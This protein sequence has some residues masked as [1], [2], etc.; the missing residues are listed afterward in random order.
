MGQGSTLKSSFKLDITTRLICLHPN[1][2]R[3]WG[4]RT[5]C[6]FKFVSPSKNSS[7]NTSKFLRRNHDSDHLYHPGAGI[8]RPLI[9][10]CPVLPNN[11]LVVA[12]G[13]K[14]SFFFCFCVLPKSIDVEIPDCSSKRAQ[15]SNIC[16]NLNLKISGCDRHGCKTADGCM[17]E[18]CNATECSEKTKSF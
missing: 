6:H 11:Y 5:I 13:R 1:R 12:R 2:L 15:Y 14:S 8:Y 18:T 9:R 3:E 4:A 10:I 7:T 16:N 17:W